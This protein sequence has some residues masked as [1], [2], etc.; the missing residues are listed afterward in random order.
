MK[1]LLAAFL[2]TAA[3]SVLLEPAVAQCTGQA[4]AGAL[5]GNSTGAQA[6]PRW[7][8]PGAFGVPTV[9]NPIGTIGLTAVNGVATTAMRSDA[10][11]VLSQSIVPTWTGVHTFASPLH[12]SG[13]SNQL[14]FQSTGVTGT[15]SWTPS[16]TNKTITLP[17]GTTNFTTTGG[18]SQVLKQVSSGAAITVARLACADLSDAGSGCSDLVTPETYGAI[19]DGTTNDAAAI[20]LWLNSGKPL[21]L[22]SRCA[23]ASAIIVNLNKTSAPTG[24]SLHGLN[25]NTSQLISN[26]TTA[27]IQINIGDYDIPGPSA[28]S[29]MGR[30]A[31]IVIR[32]IGF[33]ANVP[34]IGDAISNYALQIIGSATGGG[35]GNPLFSI[36]NI[37]MTPTST[38][39]NYFNGGIYLQDVRNGTISECA[40]FGNWGGPNGNAITFASTTAT[41]HPTDLHIV[42]CPAIQ[43]WNRGLDVRLGT[44]ADVQGI[45]VTGSTFVANQNSIVWIGA[46]HDG[47]TESTL[48][49]ASGNHFNSGDAGIALVDVYWPIIYNNSFLTMD[50]GGSAVIQRGVFLAMTQAQNMQGQVNN[51][52]FFMVPPQAT[53]TARIGVQSRGAAGAGVQNIIGGNNCIGTTQ[54]IDIDA[55][56]RKYTYSNIPNTPEASPVLT[57]CGTSP[58]IAGTDYAGVVTMG[59]GGPTGCVITFA[60]G[61]FSS[62]PLCTVSWQATPLALQSYVIA[63]ATITLTQTATSSNKVNYT[64]A[65][66]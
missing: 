65:A 12:L 13:T 37:L 31:Q 54:C 42:N 46:P 15:L 4:P 47:L 14:V 19:C 35:S 28:G 58:A 36:Q 9:A 62:P 59:T 34:N 17:N 44:N 18:T 6:L 1:R 56:D 39:T 52:T 60:S 57:S 40:L 11:P 29:P 33:M 21:L 61:G 10:A 49:I 5:C 66:P 24:L 22:R 25:V 48:L 8:L 30:G 16:S 32:D 2:S 51:N 26:S 43:W 45:Y 3:F 38:S 23:F 27:T 20:S 55:I 53:A 7:A 50:L 63:A 41:S 64:C